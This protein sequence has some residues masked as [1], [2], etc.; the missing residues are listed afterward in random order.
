[1]TKAPLLFFLFM[2]LLAQAQRCAY[3]PMAWYKQNYVKKSNKEQLK[4]LLEQETIELPIVVH[5]VWKEEEENISEAQ[6][7]SQIDVL[8]EDFQALNANL[9]IVPDEFVPLIT[10]LDIQFC[11]AQ[12]DPLGQ[13]TT[14]ITRTQTSLDF[15]G[16]A[17]TND[18]RSIYFTEEGG[19][20]AWPIEEYIN[21]WVGRRQF[22]LGE[23]SFPW[24]MELFPEGDGLV[25]DPY[26]FGRTGLAE[27]SVPFDLGRTAT[28]EMG[29]YFGLLHLNGPQASSDCSED[30]GLEDTPLQ[31]GT[32]LGECPVH[33]VASCGSND[34]FMNFMGLANDDCLAMFTMAQK[35]KILATLSNERFL[36][37]QSNNCDADTQT[38]L[39]EKE[40]FFQISPNPASDIV[41]IQVQSTFKGPKRLELF[42]SAGSL[43]LKKYIEDSPLVKVRI[44]DLN[45]GIYFIIISNMEKNITKKLII[46]R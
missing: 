35:E 15:V 17:V 38:E 45:S 19:M 2:P 20:D 23:A 24:E 44:K 8:N 1:M 28:H 36:L 39:S 26:Y 34:L 7:Q 40:N 3:S 10:T 21:I 30:D 46:A 37:A 32:Y 42:N 12:I 13:A 16:T 22:F 11:L 27:E 18:R 6:I 41:R 33:P 9:S 4:T 31:S 25:V 43:L 14:G 5:V 29:H